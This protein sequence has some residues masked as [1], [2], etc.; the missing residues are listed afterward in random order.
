MRYKLIV[1]TYNVV[2]EPN[3]R[4][5]TSIQTKNGEVGLKVWHNSPHCPGKLNAILGESVCEE[6]QGLG[7]EKQLLKKAIEIFGKESL[8]SQFQDEGFIRAA[9]ALG[10][11]SGEW[12]SLEKTLKLAQEQSSVFM[13]Y[14]SQLERSKNEK[15]TRKPSLQKSGQTQ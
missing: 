11:R 4:T 7:V 6:A 12:D 8:A 14:R 13:T 2:S 3:P 15:R 5:E 10:F 9:Y 1:E